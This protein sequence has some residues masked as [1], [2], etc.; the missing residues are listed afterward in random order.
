MTRRVTITIL[1]ALA[2][3]AMACASP[4]ANAAWKTDAGRLIPAL[5]LEE[6]HWWLLGPFKWVDEGRLFWGDRPL[7]PDGSFDLGATYDSAAGKVK[8]VEQPQWDKPNT[9][10]DVKRTAGIPEMDGCLAFYVYRQIDSPADTNAILYLGFDDGIVLNLNGSV[11]YQHF[12]Y[13]GTEP[14]REAIPVRLK[15]GRNDL[16]LKIVDKDNT[17]AAAF[18]YDL[19]PDVSPQKYASALEKLMAR[20]PD[21]AADAVAARIKL[22]WLYRQMG[23][24]SKAD[25]VARRLAMDPNA[26]KDARDAVNG[27]WASRPTGVGAISGYTDRGDRLAFKTTK[28][29]L[30]VGYWRDDAPRVTFVPSGVSLP[31]DANHRPQPISFDT[32][33]AGRP[34]DVRSE[35]DRYVI[36]GKGV[37]VEVLKDGSA[38]IMDSRGLRRFVELGMQ[39][40]M[41]RWEWSELK[42][43]KGPF[44]TAAFHLDTRE[45][46]YGM[47]NRYDSF[48]RRGRFNQV[49]NSDRAFGESHFTLPYYVTQGQ[50]ALFLN[51]FGD[52]DIDVDRINTQNIAFSR[53]QED[54]IDFFYFRGE[55]KRLVRLYVDLTGHTVMPPDWTLGVWMSRNSY[56]DENVVL[57]VAKNLRKHNIPSDVLVLE[58][59]RE[60]GQDWMK[61]NEKRWPNHEQMCKTLHDMGF[62]IVLWTMQ[63]HVFNNKDTQPYEKEAFDNHYFT[64]SGD[65]PAGYDARIDKSSLIV[66]F[67]NPAARDWW[68]KQYSKLFDPVTGI[69]GL[70]TDIGEN[71]Y[72]ETVQGWT[73]INNIYALSYIETAWDMTKDLTGQGMVFART[74][75][76]GTQKYPILWAGDHSTWFQGMQEAYNAMMNAGLA[77]YA[78]T[79]FDI[80]GLY[81]DLDK[82][83]YVRM[84]EM[85]AFCPIMQCHGMGR[86]EPFDFGDFKEEAVDVFNQYA[87]WYV[88]LKPY[89]VAAGEEA[90]RTGIPIMRPLWMEYP[91]DPM[92]YEAEFQYFFGPDI[93][94]A[95]IFSYNHT[96]TLYLPKG[97]WIDWWTGEPIKGGRAIQVTMPLEKMPLY[98][99]PG[100]S[101]LRI[102]PGSKDRQ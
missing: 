95:P 49:G 91:D 63:F 20:H 65:E 87:N 10:Y 7:A 98:V 66:D 30:Y 73:G 85:G 39:D 43:F 68:V 45:G 21:D 37:D 99:K 70:K 84:A 86:R 96:R 53:I 88:E 22:L 47:G 12:F 52:G 32:A 48:T 28:G 79:S 17:S 92:C 3:A 57:D 35:V 33:N 77:G 42:T 29:T 72:G 102:A 31:Y 90:C 40:Q 38:V 50:D 23:E 89:R 5:G 27:Y 36:D 61:W 41:K 80:G 54:V 19:Q 62:K 60:D 94:V 14:R 97:E 1:A 34:L 75:T 46:V 83:T 76:V 25:S 67:F 11:I 2:L 78:W 13:Q 69:D 58:A 26:D 81:G 56:E 24:I 82:E 16:L 8:W 101:V 93:L 55:P 100:S 4:A 15:K 51:S 6:G 64:R 59:W 18:A 9:E 44:M 71:N 74:G